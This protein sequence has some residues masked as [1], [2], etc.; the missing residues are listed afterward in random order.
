M[1]LASELGSEA[2]T[3]MAACSICLD[4]LIVGGDRATA[5]QQY[6]HEFHLG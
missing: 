6:G 3:A 5:P 4:A 1:D 2:T